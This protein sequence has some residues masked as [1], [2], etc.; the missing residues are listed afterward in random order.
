LRFL[1]KQITVWLTAEDDEKMPESVSAQSVED[2]FTIVAE[3]KKVF[4]GNI[5]LF[6]LG[7]GRAT[8]E[9]TQ[10]WQSW[11]GKHPLEGVYVFPAYQFL[12]PADYFLLDTHIN[13]FGHQKL[14]AALEKFIVE[15]GLLR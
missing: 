5:L 14:A 1:E 10:Q 11:L 15:N 9:V 7:V 13:I 6:H 4:D 2:L 8:P 3:L 12:S